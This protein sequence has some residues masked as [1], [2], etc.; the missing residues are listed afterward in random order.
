MKRT[1]DRLFVPGRVSVGICTLNRRDLA[2][3]AIESVLSQTYRNVE[4]IVSDDAS[5]DETAE[6]V[7]QISDSRVKFFQQPIRLGVVENPNFALQ[8]A[9]GEFWMFVGD[10][11]LLLPTA[12]EK[13]VTALLASSSV[14]VTWCPCRVADRSG[15]GFWTTEAGSPRETVSTMLSQLFAGN[16]GPRC[17]S[18][19]IRT[20]AAIAVGGYEARYGDLSDI[21]NWG[22]AA[23][24]YENA[25]CIREPLVQYTVHTG[26]MTARASAE[27]WQEWA[28]KVHSDM[29]QL[30]DER[31]DRRSQNELISAKSDLISGVTLTVLSLKIG[32]QGWIRETLLQ[33]IR[34]PGA[35]F[36]PYMFRRMVKDGAK[37][38]TL[39]RS[40]QEEKARAKA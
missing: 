15:S 11:D 2:V 9:T 21:G 33:T 30:L 22:R 27:Q 4:V 13:L 31:G 16:R 19:M 5:T 12:I 6:R 14:G 26:N 29:I 38:F 28:I 37:V 24:L 32:K 20:Q 36:T 39:L 25:I 23:L 17:S 40:A 7:K 18:V 35:I 10:D 8:Q 1:S 34:T 3:R